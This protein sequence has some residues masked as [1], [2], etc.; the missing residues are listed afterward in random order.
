MNLFCF[1]LEGSMD[2]LY[3]AVQESSEAQVYTIPSRS[4]SPAVL[5][6]DT[7]KWKSAGRSISMEISQINSDNTRKKK[8]RTLP[9]TVSENDALVNTICTNSVWP[10]ATKQEDL[11]LLRNN[12]NEDLVRA[13]RRAESQTMADISRNIQQAMPVQPETVNAEMTQ[14]RGTSVKKV[15]RKRSQR[16]TPTQETTA[17][18]KGA[19]GMMQDIGQQSHKQENYCISAEGSRVSSSSRH[20]WSNPTETALTWVQAYNT[21][22][23]PHNEHRV[24]TCDCTISRDKINAQNMKRDSLPKGV[25]RSTTNVDFCAPNRS[26]SFGRFDTFRNQHSPSRLEENGTPEAEGE[27]TAE[28][29]EKPGSLGKK[30]KAIS[31]TMRKRMGKKHVKSYTEDMGDD[32]E[33]E[34]ENGTPAKSTNSDRT[35]NSLESLYSGQSSSSSGGVTSNSDVSSNRDSLKLE[36]DMPYTG[37][38][39]G[40]AKV[41]TDFVPS[42]YDTDSLKLKVG[43]IISI[44]SKPPMGIWTGMLNNKVGNFK[45][46][47][48][49]VL[50]EKEKEEEDEAPKIR[51]VK[52]CKN[53]RPNTLLELLER[54]CLEEYASSLLLNGYQT[55]DDLKH[56]KERHL[57]E[58]NVTDPE[59]RRRLLAASDCLYVTSKDEEGEMKAND[60]EDED[61]DCPRD[62][63]C[64]IPA[65]CP[66]S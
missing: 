10:A 52:V 65:E 62:S 39:C 3:E 53:P 26:T 34:T 49:D 61:N 14:L 5:L 64:F 47:Y 54:L 36:E 6:D 13:V 4:R 58:L 41:H 66:D 48:V 7:N 55:V 28:N 11:V 27:S 9:K 8:Q 51:P 30:M 42:P 44:I 45:F 23:P 63:G 59:H 29:C 22:Q 43:D 15:E 56:L 24:H 16:G 21:C 37:L 32:T 12:Q 18:I 19:K 20:R 46:I 2:S 50:P 35:S 25:V 40:R 33:G 17:H 60:E 38:F 31:M 1:S 57:I